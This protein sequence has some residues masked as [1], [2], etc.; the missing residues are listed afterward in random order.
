[1]LTCIGAFQQFLHLLC[2]FNTGRQIDC[3]GGTFIP[4]QFLIAWIPGGYVDIRIDI[5]RIVLHK[6]ID[7]RKIRRERDQGVL[8]DPQQSGGRSL[9]ACCRSSKVDPAVVVAQRNA[10]NHPTEFN[11][12]QRMRRVKY[13]PQVCG[14]CVL[15]SLQRKGF[16]R[17]CKP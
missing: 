6:E 11:I 10:P 16:Q 8:D 3:G 5:P 7:I 9:R 1:M 14:D 17:L 13:L 12:T 4:N 15:L 2:S